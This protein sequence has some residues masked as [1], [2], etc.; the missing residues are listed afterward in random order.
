MAN[1]VGEAPPTINAGCYRVSASTKGNRGT[2]L[3]VEYEYVID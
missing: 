3:S 1:A 2:H